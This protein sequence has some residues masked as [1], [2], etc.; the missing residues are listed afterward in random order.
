VRTDFTES[1]RLTPPA[2]VV[3]WLAAAM[4]SAAMMFVAMMFAGC[5]ERHKLET[6]APPPLGSTISPAAENA[7]GSEPPATT[8]SGIATPAAPRRSHTSRKSAPHH[9]PP[10]PAPS[11][12]GAAI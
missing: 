7:R 3:T 6:S 9:A 12:T 8:A 11:A 2:F 1:T 5:S 10:P 4:M